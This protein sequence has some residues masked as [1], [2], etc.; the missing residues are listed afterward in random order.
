MRRFQPF[1]VVAPVAS[2]ARD[3]LP[4]WQQAIRRHLR[5]TECSPLVYPRPYG[6]IR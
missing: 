4:L 5:G 3:R 6:G 1:P 2:S